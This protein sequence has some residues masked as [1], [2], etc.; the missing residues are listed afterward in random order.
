MN[1]SE[2]FE[3][4]GYELYSDNENRLRYVRN[5]HTKHYPDYIEVEFLKFNKS[6]VVNHVWDDT[7]NANFV[8]MSLYEAIQQQL[9]E[10]GWI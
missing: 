3:K 4:L 8:K 7:E 1:A 2:I 9:K 5:F 6:F 10:L